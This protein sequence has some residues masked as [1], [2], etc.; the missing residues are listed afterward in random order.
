MGVGIDRGIELWNMRGP[1]DYCLGSK[2]ARFLDV[3]FLILLNKRNVKNLTTRDNHK[4]NEKTISITTRDRFQSLFLRHH[5]IHPPDTP[6]PPCQTSPSR[7][8]HPQHDSVVTQLRSSMSRRAFNKSMRGY[9][10]DMRSFHEDM[11]EAGGM[12]SG[13]M[14][15][16][17][18]GF[19]GG[20]VYLGQRGIYVGPFA[21]NGGGGGCA[22]GMYIG[23]NGI[24]AGPFGGYAGGGGGGGRI[25]GRG[26]PGGGGP[27]GFGGS[28]RGG[29]QGGGFTS[30]FGGGGGHGGAGSRRSGRSRDGSSVFNGPPDVIDGAGQPGLGSRRSGRAGWNAGMPMRTRRNNGNIFFPGFGNFVMEFR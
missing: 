10:Q 13:G 23:Q 17:D 25:G 5:K 15:G 21:G 2:G 22:G 18:G 16:G 9:Q 27:S 12:F 26:Y 1:H 7:E 28:R 30:G 4:D 24:Y 19:W 20:G 3:D 14:N 8:K 29:V 11:R 6:N